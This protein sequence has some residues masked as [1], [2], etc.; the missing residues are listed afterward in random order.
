MRICN[1]L[2]Q[3]RGHKKS[4]LCSETELS[5]IIKPLAWKKAQEKVDE[6]THVLIIAANC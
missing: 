6:V 5:V 4:T 1:S 3:Q 2:I